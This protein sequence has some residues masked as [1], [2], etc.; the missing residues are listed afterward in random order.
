[1]SKNPRYPPGGQTPTTEYSARATRNIR[2]NCLVPRIGDPA[3]P[4]T[5][6]ASAR[7]PSRSAAEPAIHEWKCSLAHKLACTQRPLFAESDVCWGSGRSAA[8]PAARW[9]YAGAVRGNAGVE[10]RMSGCTVGGQARSWWALGVGEGQ[11]LLELLVGLEDVSGEIA[12][13]LDRPGVL[14]RE[15]FGGRHARPRWRTGRAVCAGCAHRDLRRVEFMATLPLE[16]LMALS[17][18]VPICGWA[19]RGLPSRER[20]PEARRRQGVRIRLAIEAHL[21]SGAFQPELHP[22]Q[23]HVT[24]I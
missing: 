8:W 15:Q 20:R 16:P 7:W 22:R 12:G 23:D 10:E 11:K 17:R 24:V 5:D 4:W 3:N 21:L 9:A 2:R 13:G 18:S 14:S 6:V 1:M 19:A